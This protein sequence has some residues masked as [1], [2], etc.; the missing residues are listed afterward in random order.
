VN[1]KATLIRKL[2]TSK[3]YRDAFVDSEIS[4]GLP[5]QIRALRDSRGWSQ[6]D[7]ADATSMLQP[8][9]CAM[10]QAGYG[11]F[12]LNTLKKLAAAFDVAL[13]VKF[14]P[15]AELIKWA[16]SFSPDTFA[17]PSAADDPMLTKN[18]DLTDP[19]VVQSDLPAI[20]DHQLQQ[21]AQEAYASA[22]QTLG[23]LR[24]AAMQGMQGNS[25]NPSQTLA[26]RLQAPPGG[27]EM[28]AL[29]ARAA[30]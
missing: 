1:T 7:L 23:G 4:V 18:Q 13:V 10:E 25:P 16:E 20:T 17:V 9:I 6:K 8:R 12:T 15:F 3:E 28:A 11:N 29:S 14:A 22:N 30:A 5:F 2:K 21:L 27:A 24:A 26:G 19:R